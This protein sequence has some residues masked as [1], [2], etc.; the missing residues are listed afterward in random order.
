MQKKLIWDNVF[1]NG[2][3]KSCG[4]QPLK[5]VTRPNLEY[6]VAYIIRIEVELCER[7]SDF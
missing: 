2:P 3:S 7:V 6:F 5:N 1:K 4:R